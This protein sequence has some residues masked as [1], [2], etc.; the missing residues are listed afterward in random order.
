MKDNP[1][2][3]TEVALRERMPQLVNDDGDRDRNDPQ[4]DFNR[5][6]ISTADSQN[7]RDHPK[8]GVDTD[9]NAQQPKM[10]IVLAAWGFT[11]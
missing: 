8:Q 6:R 11:Q 5:R 10:E 4:Q 1:W 7:Q 9:G 2:S 3:T